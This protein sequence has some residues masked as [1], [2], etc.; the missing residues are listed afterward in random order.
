MQTVDVDQEQDRLP[1]ELTRLVGRDR[2]LD[3]LC[4]A[5]PTTRLLTLVGVGGAGKSRLALALA[6]AQDAS[7]RYAELGAVHDPALLPQAVAA[8]L[9]LGEVAAVELPAA[10]ARRLRGRDL[11]LLDNCEHVA[12]TCAA[13]AARLLAACPA[14]TIVATSRHVLGVPGERVIRVSG[15]RLATGEDGRP[16]EA[17]ELFLERA[18]FAAPSFD[19]V[20]ETLPGIEGLCR[21]LDGLPLAIELAAAR[22]RMLT[23]HEIA[24]RLE[25]D[26]SFLRQAG[27]PRRAH[28]RTL[29]ATLDFSHGLLTRCEAVLLRRLAAFDGS[30][31]LSAA[32]AVAAGGELE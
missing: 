9:G 10:A 23:V 8:A 5:L 19:P 1:A 25:H 16:S 24:S 17:A 4:D 6:R 2:E 11:L 27:A 7:P 18:R 29:L 32:E 22:V 14:L 12:G 3:E 15:L 20:P 21:R 26:L 28:H 31:P 13:L 30:F